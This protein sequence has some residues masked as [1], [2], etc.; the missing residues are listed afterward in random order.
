MHRLLAAVEPPDRTADPSPQC[1]R[2]G[3]GQD[4]GAQ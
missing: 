3:E 2:T 4:T 1:P